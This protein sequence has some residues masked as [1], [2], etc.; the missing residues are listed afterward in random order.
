MRRTRIKICGICRPEDAAWAVQCGA[1]AIGMVFHSPSP[2]S[3]SID[4]A[5]AILR[6][7]PPFVTAVAL[8]VDASV[9]GILD[10]ARTLGI[11]TVQLHGQE[12]PELVAR[13][14]PLVVLKAVKVE[15]STFADALAMWKREIPTRELD[16]LRGLLL[17]TGNTPEP[18]GT[19]LANDWETV[20]KAQSARLFDGLP[21]LIAAGGLTPQSVGGI[22]RALRPYAVDV[23]SGVE[24][25]RRQKSPEKIEA[26]VA[27]VREGDGEGTKAPR[28]QGTK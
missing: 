5:R 13:V 20:L 1:D 9:D 17:E 14:K 25:L 7:L 11:G 26:F 16:N 23:S 22:V 6:V 19:G 10:T 8:F 2:R 24:E 21:P 3:V 15:K 12:V 4:Q 18:G 28:H 27:A